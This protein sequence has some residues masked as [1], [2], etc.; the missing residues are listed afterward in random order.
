MAGLPAGRGV[1]CRDR[2]GMGSTYSTDFPGA[3]RPPDAPT[4]SYF[5]GRFD[6]KGATEWLRYAPQ[7]MSRMDRDGTGRIH[8]AGSVPG[9]V[10]FAEETAVRGSPQAFGNLLWLTLDADGSGIANATWLGTGG[11]T[12][13]N[14]FAVGPDGLARIVGSTSSPSFWTTPGAWTKSPLEG[15]QWPISIDGFVSVA[16]LP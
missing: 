11:N 3:D 8:L 5:L 15:Q 16:P 13:V 1:S 7:G 2:G 12:F 4:F 14:G 6:E 9:P 10:A